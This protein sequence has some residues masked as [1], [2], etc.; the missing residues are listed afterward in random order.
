MSKCASDRTRHFADAVGRKGRQTGAMS[1]AHLTPARLV[2]ADDRAGT[3][4]ALRALLA[5]Q[6]DIEVVGEAADG[7]KAVWL[8]GQL[9]PDLVLLDL[10]MPRLDGIAAAARIKA[11]WPTTRVVAH[12]FAVERQ[13]EAFNAGFDAFVAKGTPVEDLLGALSAC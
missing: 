8:V 13:A 12:S 11:Q 1:S 5:S 4:R 3:R 2:I 10:R 9:R 6:R 7:E